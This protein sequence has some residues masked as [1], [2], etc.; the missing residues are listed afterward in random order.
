MF[1]CLHPKMKCWT[2]LLN[3]IVS[4]RLQHCSVQW[5]SIWSNLIKVTWLNQWRITSITEMSRTCLHPARRK[6][7]AYGD[8]AVSPNKIAVFILHCVSLYPWAN[9]HSFRDKV[10][11]WNPETDRQVQSLMAFWATCSIPNMKSLEKSTQFKLPGV[12]SNRSNGTISGICVA[13][14]H[15]PC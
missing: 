12:L 8:P 7:L 2:L 13:N 9:Q 3:C 14:R 10:T 11:G 6:H 15:L 5:R 1:S 4:W